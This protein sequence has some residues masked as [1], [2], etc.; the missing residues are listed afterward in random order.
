M[1][2]VPSCRTLNRL[3]MILLL[4]LLI[5]PELV[6]EL[7]HNRMVQRLVGLLGQELGLG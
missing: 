5:D 3:T 4:L 6:T 7:F 2:L 1:L